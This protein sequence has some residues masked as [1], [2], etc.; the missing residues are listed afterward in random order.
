MRRIGVDSRAAAYSFGLLRK[1]NR[2]G[3]QKALDQMS[4]RTPRNE[5]DIFR[6]EGVVASVHDAHPL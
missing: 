6:N 4:T 3:V 5:L 2:P 1:R